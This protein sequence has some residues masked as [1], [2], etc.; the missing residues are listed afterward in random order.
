MS[1]PS[2]QIRIRLEGRLEILEAAVGRYEAFATLLK[3]NWQRR[4]IADP[5]RRARLRLGNV[6]VAGVVEIG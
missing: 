1:E 4:A 3:G 5:T 6:H 2:N